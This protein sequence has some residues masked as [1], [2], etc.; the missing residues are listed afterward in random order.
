VSSEQHIRLASVIVYP[1][2]GARGVSVVRWPIDAFGLAMDR[3]WMLVD[4][5]GNNLKQTKY[6][7]LA[8]IGTRIETGMLTV[9]AADL[10]D[11]VLPIPEEDAP[12]ANVMVEHDWVTVRE[13]D[14]PT[15]EWFSELL[16]MSCRAVYMPDR[17]ARTADP[18]YAPGSRLSF[19]NSYPIHL[20]SEA[21]LDLLNLRL[22]DPIKMD[23]F[24]PN[25]VVSGVQPHEEDEWKRIQ[26]GGG[27][28]MNVVKPCIH[29]CGM[30]NVDQQ[31]AAR[32]TEALRTLATYRLNAEGVCFGS[33]V[34]P[35]GEGHVAQ[36]ASIQVIERGPR[37]PLLPL[38]ASP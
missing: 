12:A 33:N 24:R 30:L 15:S 32:N 14:R 7:R 34:I 2:K 35:A 13:L 25:L 3:R 26:V 1:L 4:D 5:E 19:P 9:S 38:P 10:P 27:A 21:S 29:S 23:R 36:G 8:V 18:A 20:T 11:L 6:P 17:G 31:T 16:E 22:S 28:V 37:D